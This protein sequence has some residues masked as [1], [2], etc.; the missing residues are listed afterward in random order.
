[1][2][3]VARNEREQ[4][5]PTWSKIQ[6]LAFSTGQSSQDIQARPGLGWAS[7]PSTGKPGVLWAAP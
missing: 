5:S 7:H 2:L 6:A 1:M 4:F 3:P